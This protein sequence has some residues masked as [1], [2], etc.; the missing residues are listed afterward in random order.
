[1]PLEGAC[2]QPAIRLG[3]AQPLPHF[4]EGVLCRS[5]GNSSSGGG[6]GRG[7]LSKHVTVFVS[8][9]PRK[10]DRDVCLTVLRQL[11]L[12][13]GALLPRSPMVVVFDGPHPSLVK[14]AAAGQNLT[15]DDSRGWHGH[16][17]R[18]AGSDARQVHT[19]PRARPAVLWHTRAWRVLPPSHRCS[20]TIGPRSARCAR[21][22]AS[23]W[24]RTRSGSTRASRC[25]TRWPRAPRPSSSR[26]RTTS[27]WCAHPLC[28]S[29][30]PLRPGSRPHLRPSPF[31]LPNLQS[32]RHVPPY[33]L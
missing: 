29:C 7:D 2:V 30:H 31:A 22:R 32:P 21:R 16:G 23:R 14:E 20:A 17:K 24:S 25:A 27:S 15:G 5:R 6:A 33:H 28:H 12:D 4:S 11:V 19:S 3:C 8:S 1:M 26:Y 9:S 10:G 13:V 18:W